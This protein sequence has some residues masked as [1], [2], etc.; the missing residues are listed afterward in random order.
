LASL[1]RQDEAIT[2]INSLR[3]HPA[4]RAAVPEGMRI[5][6]SD[7]LGRLLTDVVTACDFVRSRNQCKELADRLSAHVDSIR[8]L[9]SAAPMLAGKEQA[10]G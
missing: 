1:E 4:E 2:A 6:S 3:K 5:V 8:H 10:N 7:E 9:S